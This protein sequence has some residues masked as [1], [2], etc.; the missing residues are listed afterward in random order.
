[1]CTTCSRHK[2]GCT[3]R[4]CTLCSGVAAHTVPPH[5]YCA[6]RVG[7][8]VQA[9]TRYLCTLALCTLGLVYPQP[10]VPSALCTLGPVYPRPCEPPA[11][12]TLSPVY[13]RPRNPIFLCDPTGSKRLGFCT[14]E[15]KTTANNV[16]FLE[17]QGN[18]PAAF[19]T[20]QVNVSIALC[21]LGPVY[22]QPCVPPPSCTLNPKIR[23]PH[24]ACGW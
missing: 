19:A 18:R 23:Y 1:M 10:C 9:R 12:F 17:K 21:T 11:L 8:A 20:D 2:A 3:A 13:P 5:E 14:V 15:T 16:C 6:A 24:Y 22:P 4:S 7:E